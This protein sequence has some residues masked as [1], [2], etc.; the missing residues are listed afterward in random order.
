VFERPTLGDNA[1]AEEDRL[2]AALGGSTANIWSNCPGSYFYKKDLPPQLPTKYTDEGTKAHSVA[3]VALEDFLESKISGIDPQRRLLGLDPEMVAHALA[4]VQALWDNCLE[5]SIT[6]KF[7]GLEEKY[8][9][10]E[11]FDMWGYCDFWA[12]H[13]DDRAKRRGIIVD[14][15]YGYN[16]VSIEKNAQLAFYACSLQEEF[17]EKGKELDYVTAVIFQPRCEAEAYKEVKFTNTQLK[18]WRKKFLKAGAQIFLKKKPIFKVGDHCKWCPAKAICKTYS[19]QMVSD[20][21]LAI[22]DTK[23]T[24]PVPEKLDDASLSKIILNAD[25]LEEFLTACRKYGVARYVK[26]TPIPGT[27][28]VAGTPRR[29]W[30]ED[31]DKII[32]GL[33]KLGISSPAE[34]KLRGITEINK[35][36]KNLFGKDT[37]EKTLASFCDLSAPSITLVSLDDPRQAVAN[38]K[39]LL[40]EITEE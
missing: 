12:V 17:T 15:K 31:S 23:I 30:K 10:S 34:P 27:K 40:T 13:V 8:I 20:T 32:A 35:E 4:Y 39:D 18:Q 36:L 25:K 6:G 19:R 22:V 14:Y 3:E 28:C 9:L 33:T 24:L 38:V 7:Y 1:M 21:D 2:H 16:K 29:K 26:G 37:A 11:E 5:K